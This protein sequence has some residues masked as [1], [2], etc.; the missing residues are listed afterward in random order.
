M[1]SRIKF[2]NQFAGFNLKHIKRIDV[3]FNPFHQ[4]AAN[5]REFYQGV[6]ER[7]VINSNPECSL[8]AKV[9]CDDSDPMVNVL[10]ADEHKLVINSKYLESGHLLRLIKEIKE[11]HKEEKL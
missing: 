5:L 7:K 10:F 2:L 9:V 4:N 8:K 11:Q 6:T 3:K 1:R